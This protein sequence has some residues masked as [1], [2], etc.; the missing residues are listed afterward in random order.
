MVEYQKYTDLLRGGS[1]QPSQDAGAGLGGAAPTLDGLDA[2]A[3]ERPRP[4]QHSAVSETWS[5]RKPRSERKGKSQS[6]ELIQPPAW[7]TSGLEPDQ[8]EPG[9]DEACQAR[10]G[11]VE[12][13]GQL[14]LHFC[15]KCGAWGAYGHG[16]NL[17]AGRTGRWY[18]AVHR[19]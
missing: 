13:R 14:F 19:P 1:R 17:R 11:R 16:V 9:F 10:R 12:Q 5:K 4:Q 3:K 8:G 6:A 18:C 15:V 2:L 7:F